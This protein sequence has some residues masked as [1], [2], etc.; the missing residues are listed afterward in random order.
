MCCNYKDLKLFVAKIF[1][2]LRFT[3]S[4]L[5]S[6]P[7]LLYLSFVNRAGVVIL[8]GHDSKGPNNGMI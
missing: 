3:S 2:A 8:T 6:H 4:W 1:F 7:P 5:Q